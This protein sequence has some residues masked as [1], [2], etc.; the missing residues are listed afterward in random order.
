MIEHLR[1]LIGIS[2]RVAVS[3]VEDNSVRRAV[4]ALL[5]K[6]AMLDGEVDEVEV[7]QARKILAER[8]GLSREDADEILAEGRA[9]ADDAVDHYGFT[10]VIRDAFDHDERVELVGQIWEI[11]LADGEVHD[12]EAALMR[13]LGGLLHVSD[14]E[15][16]DARKQAV[17]KLGLAG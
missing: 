6:A 7:D 1:K 5:A 12:Y 15:N 10:R 16:G 2:P 14:R 8:F 9:D 11:V 4:A 13:R 17:V 3:D